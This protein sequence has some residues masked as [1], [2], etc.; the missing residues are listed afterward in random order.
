MS[1]LSNFAKV[2]ILC[3]AC[4][5]NE[6]TISTG[7]VRHFDYF[8][9]PVTAIF[10]TTDPEKIGIKCVIEPNGDTCAAEVEGTIT[11]V[12][13]SSKPVIIAHASTRSFPPQ[14]VSWLND[15]GRNRIEFIPK[16]WFT[17]QTW[18]RD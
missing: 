7:N 6:Q 4:E 5:T 13:G 17:P 15:V 10:D 18:L 16:G 2:C 9:K 12:S 3:T 11:F 8:D 1:K 14:L